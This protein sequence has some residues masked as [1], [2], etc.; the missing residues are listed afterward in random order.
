MVSYN[1][2]KF[3]KI[4]YDYNCN[5]HFHA[6]EILCLAGFLKDVTGSYDA[7]FYTSGCMITLVSGFLTMQ[8]LVSLRRQKQAEEV[9]VKSS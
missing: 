7:G 9:S 1:I 5:Y 4:R 6:V 8:G 3:L 2:H